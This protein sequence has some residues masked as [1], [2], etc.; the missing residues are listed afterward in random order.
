M[1]SLQ[2]P[3]HDKRSI[4]ATYRSRRKPLEAGSH[5]LTGIIR[6]AKILIVAPLVAGAYQ[7]STLIYL[8][9][10][11]SAIKCATVAALTF[12][13]LTTALFVADKGLAA[14]I[15]KSDREPK[16]EE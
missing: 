4:R 8:G 14:A 16:T 6:S 1:A 2:R 9:Q 5:T 13:I 7:I 11:W 10:Y 15:T 3:T 12:L